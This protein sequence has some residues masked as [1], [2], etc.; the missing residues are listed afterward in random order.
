MF[1]SICN[2]KTQP[3]FHVSEEVGFIFGYLKKFASKCSRCDRYLDLCGVILADLPLYVIDRS[4]K[5][6]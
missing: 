1:S 2:N 3:R 6:C 5:P 4:V